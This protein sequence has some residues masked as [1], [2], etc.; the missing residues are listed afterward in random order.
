M[1][2]AE[3]DGNFP[4]E[5]WQR[6]IAHGVAEPLDANAQLMKVKVAMSPH[7]RAVQAVSVRPALQRKMLEDTAS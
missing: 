1:R 3:R 2:R 7:R 5:I 4:Q 6:V